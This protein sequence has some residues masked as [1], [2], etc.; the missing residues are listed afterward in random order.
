MPILDEEGV[1]NVQLVLMFLAV[2]AVMLYALL[3]AEII[4]G[5]LAIFLV[6]GYLVILGA[7]VVKEVME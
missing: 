2:P 5:F 1:R 7:F 4:D 3:N 6:V